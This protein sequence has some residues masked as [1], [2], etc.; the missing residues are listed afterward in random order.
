MSCMG[1]N[2]SVRSFLLLLLMKIVLKKQFSVEKYSRSLYRRI[3]GSIHWDPLAR[4]CPH[5]LLGGLLDALY[6]RILQGRSRSLS[7]GVLPRGMVG[8]GRKQVMPAHKLYRAKI[9][10]A[11]LAD[12][13]R[14]VQK[15]AQ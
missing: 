11:R 13:R 3:L 6:R 7:R 15:E 14:L 9:L 8:L 10:A 2:R 12:S 5:I 1:Y 4:M